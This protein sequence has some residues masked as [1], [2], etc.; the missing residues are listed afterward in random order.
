[1]KILPVVVEIGIN[2]VMST[3]VYTFCGKF[4]LQCNGGHIGLCSTACLAS[5]IMKLWDTAWIDLLDREEIQLF[6]HFR[7]VDDIRDFLRPLLHGVRWS[8]GHFK[9]K[10]EWAPTDRESGVSDQQRTAQRSRK[11]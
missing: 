10:E 6:D 9:F 3:H 4:Y 8:D 5:L 11:L 2:L 1:M 7:Y